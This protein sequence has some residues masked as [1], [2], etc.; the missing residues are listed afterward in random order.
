MQPFRI[1]KSK[2]G[3]LLAGGDQR[4]LSVAVFSLYFSWMLAFPFEGQV[5][6]ALTARTGVR[7]QSAVL[8]S[9][10]V[11]AV[12]LVCCGFIVRTL[13]AARG[14]LRFSV[15]VCMI[16]SGA[17]FFISPDFWPA[18]LVLVSFMGSLGLAS[19]GFYYKNATPANQRIKT[20]A[21]GLI[22]SNILMIAINMTAIHL[23]AYAGLAL[24]MLCLAGAAMLTFRLSEPSDVT[25]PPLRPDRNQEARVYKPLALLC[26]FVVLI[27][28]NSGLMYQ[29]VNPAFAHHAWLVSWYWALPY[30]V[31][32][33]IMR[34]LRPSI[35]RH[36]ILYVAISMI[37]LAFIA[38]MALDRS[39]LSYL[40]VDTLLLG[41]CG[42][43]DLF[44][45]SIL[46]EMLDYH[47]NPVMILGVGLSANVL[48]VWLGGVVGS[49]IYSS[50]AGG[51]Q[52]S[53]L[54][55]AVVCV[56]L[57]I[58]PPLHRRLLLLLKNHAYLSVLSE[59]PEVRQ[60]H[61][62]DSF[63]AMGSLTERE[64]QI[65]SRLMQGKTYKMIAGELTLS[66]N[67]VKTH[68]KNIYG[69]FQVQSRIELL[70][71]TMEMQLSKSGD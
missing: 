16:G 70:N 40:V 7:P 2:K 54:A 69:K 51:L 64:K 34:N 60:N 21:D 53:L 26:L 29:V 55:L 32:L 6:Y 45:W 4:L 3:L 13:K 14:M 57:V 28:I 50:E 59:M 46:G 9:V 11:H 8:L 41:A 20:A 43:Y 35:N 19:W 37:G 63:A 33:Y 15:A 12:G 17:F 23:S 47:R 5:Y 52:S 61:L 44:W 31:A 67:T 49:A 27:T 36:Y 48:G 18:L 30:V 22:G 71:K 25:A 56:T 65:A 62:A 42:V 68:V 58:L 24:S 1:L 39:A 66:E 10:L 38:F